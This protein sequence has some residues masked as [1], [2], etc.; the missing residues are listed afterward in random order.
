MFLRI[1]FLK[2]PQIMFPK[3]PVL[4]SPANHVYE[5]R[6]DAHGNV[7]LLRV[8]VVCICWFHLRLRFKNKQ[9]TSAIWHKSC[10][11]CNSR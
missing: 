6:G 11:N 1:L 10:T 3:I 2:L 5:R 9:W 8:Q 4:A 7:S